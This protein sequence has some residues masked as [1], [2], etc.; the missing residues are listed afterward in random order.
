LTAVEQAGPVAEVG[1]FQAARGSFSARGFYSGRGVCGQASIKE[2]HKL[3]MRRI[4]H[5]ALWAVLSMTGVAGSSPTSPAPAA[6]FVYVGNAESNEISVLRLDRQTGELTLVETMAIPGVVKAGMSTPMAVSPDRRFLY[7]GTRGEPQSVTT[8]AIDAKSGQLRHVGSGPLA[9]SM[10]YI[11]TDRT[12]RF[13][14]A[15]SYPGHKLTVSVIDSHGIV[16]PARQVLENHPNAHAILPDA[17]NRYVLATTLGNDLVNVFRFDAAGG[18]LEPN[19]PPSVA[20]KAKTGPRHLAFHPNGKLVYVLG[21]LDATVHVFD[22]DAGK[23]LL[24]E[25]QSVSAL[26]PGTAGRVAAADLHVT[27]DGKFL[28]CSERASNTISGFRVNAADGTLTLIESIPTEEVPRGF[29]VDSAG[30]YV[31]VAGQRSHRLSSYRI[32]PETGR[33]AKLKEY[34]V[35]KNPNWIEVVD[36]PAR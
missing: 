33:L 1:G 17:Q 18:K 26:P 20:L 5:Q 22:Y 30:R 36:L 23:G 27:P 35:G 12:G 28:Y 10:A 31:F 9:D 2:E 13:L 34:L 19:A 8:F 15:A 11:A 4:L 21:E 14:L 32:N 7:V 25:K 24:K 3:G 29:A 16:G 6:T